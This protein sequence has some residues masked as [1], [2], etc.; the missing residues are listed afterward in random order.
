M[1]LRIVK[2]K[3]AIKDAFF[4]LRKTTPLEK[5]WVRDICKKALINKS[6]FYNHYSDVFILSDELENELLIERFE[7][8]EYK[9]CLFS[10]PKTFIK[11]IPKAIDQN[12]E[13]IHILFHD[14]MEVL[15]Q[16]LQRQLYDYYKD[17]NASPEYDILLTFIIGGAMQ[18]MQE[19]SSAKKYSVDLTVNCLSDC[20]GKLS[21][22]E[23]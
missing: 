13:P 20:I 5:L 11:E 17:P 12:Y 7:K 14:R 9:D 1:D 6:T 2:T 4:E 10:D 19:I 18:A 22:V 21:P 16:K 3:R 23:K 15:Y 8:F